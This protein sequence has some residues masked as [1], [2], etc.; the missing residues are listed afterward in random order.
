MISCDAKSIYSV[1]IIGFPKVILAIMIRDL[2][3]TVLI[4]PSLGLM[5]KPALVVR[6]NSAT[7]KNTVLV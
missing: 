5:L 6:S 4:S 2:K 3:D 7:M 1:P